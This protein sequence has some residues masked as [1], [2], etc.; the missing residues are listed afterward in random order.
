MKL[1]PLNSKLCKSQIKYI[2]KLLEL[3]ISAYNVNFIS[4]SNS[5]SKLLFQID[6][7][8]HLKIDRAISYQILFQFDFNLYKRFSYT[9]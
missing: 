3:S 7:T 1:N 9:L 5:I 8:I 6:F 2:I 4:N